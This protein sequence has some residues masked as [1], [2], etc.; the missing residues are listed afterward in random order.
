MIIIF[1]VNIVGENMQLMSL[2]DISQ[3]VKI[4]LTN[5]EESNH[6]KYNRSMLEEQELLNQISQFLQF[7]LNQALFKIQE[8]VEIKS[9]VYPLRSNQPRFQKLPLILNRSLQ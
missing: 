6:L 1:N 3:N 4:L 2:K 8:Q 9:Q 7:I 5:Q